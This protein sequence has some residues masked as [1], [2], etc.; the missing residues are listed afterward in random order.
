M[1]LRDRLRRVAGHPAVR[2]TLT[3]VAFLIVYLASA[4]PREVDQLTPAA[5]VRIPVELLLGV[6]LLLVLPPRIRRAGGGGRR[7]RCWAC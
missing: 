2:A 6:A 4:L 3:A 1:S 7:R 5:L